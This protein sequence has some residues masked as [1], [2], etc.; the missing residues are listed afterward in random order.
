MP[1]PAA[2]ATL[3]NPAQ[4][5][6]QPARTPRPA[7][8]DSVFL[9]PRI[10]DQRAFDD[11]SKELKVLIK[12]ADGQGE[13]LKKTTGD[14]RGLTGVLRT[15]LREL[16]ERLERAGKVSPAL[17]QWV[18][19][20][21]ELTAKGLDPRRV[22]RELERAVEGIVESRKAE[23]EH[24]VAPTVE[25]LR[26]LKRETDRLRQT[27]EGLLDEQKLRT[28]IGDAISEGIDKSVS[29][30]VEAAV[31]PAVELAT[32]RVE[33]LEERTH[34]ACRLL[35]EHAARA[36]ELETRTRY[37]IDA[38]NDRAAQ[39]ERESS[40]RFAQAE[41]RLA[42]VERR[43][44]GWIDDADRRAAALIA[45]TGSVLAQVLEAQ[46]STQSVAAG[47]EAGLEKV[48]DRAHGLRDDSIAPLEKSLTDLEARATRLASLP[49]TLAHGEK[50]LDEARHAGR[51]AE[52]I[53]SQMDH[54][55][56]LLGEELLAAAARIDEIAGKAE[57]LPAPRA[58]RLNDAA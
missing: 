54:A 40:E 7:A 18:K 47:L 34:A 5:A 44:K 53:R 22:A 58:P 3:P 29:A 21:Q 27:A 55:R 19:D 2:P 46:N 26:H 51:Q 16:Q 6:T 17:E 37:T 23:F 50:L 36:E 48:R 43:I 25:T 8:D 4:T 12:D 1:Q 41:D 39:L 31:R 14:V 28:R 11:L 33:L 10:L 32:A 13:A 49:G 35:A 20:A 9:T 52:A 56:T 24:A 57:G 38:L 15:A 30:A 45:R 42:A